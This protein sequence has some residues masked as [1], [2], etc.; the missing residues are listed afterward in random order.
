[1]GDATPTKGGNTEGAGIE[2]ERLGF[3]ELSLKCLWDV[4][5]TRAGCGV[6]VAWRPGERGLRSKL[7]M[8]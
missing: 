6:C 8:G 4:D 5:Q 1:M 3:D 2:V 7:E